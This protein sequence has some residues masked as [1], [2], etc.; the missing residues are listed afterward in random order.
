MHPEEAPTSTPAT[1]VPGAPRSTT[2]TTVP[3]ASV[4][5]TATCCDESLLS[6]GEVRFSCLPSYQGSERKFDERMNFLGFERSPSQP[7]TLGDGNCGVYSLLD[8]LN[9]PTSDPLSMFERD[10]ALFARYV[11]RF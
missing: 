10:D 7:F 3:S 11:E 9:L 8:Q 6:E 5:Q 2:A 1:S 4:N